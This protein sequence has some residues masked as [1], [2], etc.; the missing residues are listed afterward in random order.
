MVY[1]HSYNL[2]HVDADGYGV[3]NLYEML[4]GQ[5][6]VLSS[7]YLDE[8]QCLELLTR[9]RSSKMYRPDQNS[10]LLYPDRNLPLVREKNVIDPSLVQRATAGFRMNWHQV[11]E[12]FVEQDV[13]AAVHFNGSFR[14][15]KE[16]RT[17]LDHETD[18]SAKHK[19][20]LV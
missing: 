12:T 19:N 13:N 10:Y 3:E 8:R 9:L 4:E 6:A 1:Y 2:L 7:G 17:A 5:V 15:A 16:L 11:E 14:N 20:R 18:I